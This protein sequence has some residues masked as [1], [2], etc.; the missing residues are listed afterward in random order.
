MA[1]PAHGMIG[2]LLGTAFQALIAVFAGSGIVEVGVIKV[3]PAVETCGRPSFGIKDN[4]PNKRRS[5]IAVLMKQIR[6]IGKF[7]TQGFG[8]VVY[9]VV[10]RIGSGQ[11]DSVRRSCQRNLCVCARENHALLG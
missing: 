3:K 10:L 11:Q 7:R 8:K 5:M 6:Q 4:G 2:D 9:V 1:Q